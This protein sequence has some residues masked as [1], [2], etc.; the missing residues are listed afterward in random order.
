[1]T[2]TVGAFLEVA[3]WKK[4]TPLWRESRFEVKMLNASRARIA[5]GSSEVEK[6]R[7]VV[8]RST[9]GKLRC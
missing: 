1:M 7:A 5:F 3:M 9:F 6:V 2:M 8:A 4:C